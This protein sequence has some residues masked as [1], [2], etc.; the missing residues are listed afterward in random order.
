MTSLE[1]WSHAPADSFNYPRFFKKV[2]SL[3]QDP[4]DPWAIDTLLFLTK[5]DGFQCHNL[6]NFEL[7]RQ[8][9]T[10]RLSRKRRLAEIDDNEDGG[11][12]ET[13]IILQQ[14]AARLLAA[15]DEANR[16]VVCC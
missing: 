3:F 12:D 7:S 4:Q 10:L 15:E 2:L 1:N 13:E 5:Y 8:L 11:P 9:P 14:R 6:T 16:A